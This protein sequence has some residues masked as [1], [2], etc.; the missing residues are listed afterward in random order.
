MALKVPGT[1][2]EEHLHLLGE[3]QHAASLG[4]ETGSAAGRLLAVLRPHMEKEETLALP[5]LGLLRGL[6]LAE[7][8][9]WVE[10]ARALVVQFRQAYPGMLVDHAQIAS[11]LG[12]LQEAA[13]R[14]GHP[15]VEGLAHALEHHARLEEEVLYPAALL[16]ELALDRSPTPAR[17]RAPR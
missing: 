4:G 16:V 7:A 6:A 13:T 12:R 17:G 11:L 10:E 2:K 5:L 9:S 1:I 15:H 8:P 3:V 14:E